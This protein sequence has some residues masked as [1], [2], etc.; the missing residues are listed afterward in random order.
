M[1][2]ITIVVS[3]SFLFPMVQGTLNTEQ[4]PIIY[5]ANIATKSR[6]EMWGLFDNSLLG[7]AYNA[8]NWTND[9]EFNEK[10]RLQIFNS[11]LAWVKNSIFFQDDDHIFIAVPNDTVVLFKTDAS[12]TS[13]KH[14]LFNRKTEFKKWSSEKQKM[15][16]G[17]NRGNHQDR[18][19]FLH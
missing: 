11:K 17:I 3:T 8:F 2:Q 16:K 14:P 5:L 15:L 18:D 19:G 1:I 12:W 10:R 6:I 4:S 9:Q 13:F 7:K